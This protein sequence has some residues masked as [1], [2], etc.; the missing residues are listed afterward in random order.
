[1]LITQTL[2][3]YDMAQKKGKDK[4]LKCQHKYYLAQQNVIGTCPENYP[5]QNFMLLAPVPEIILTRICWL[6]ILP[7]VISE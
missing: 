4:F 3:S 5:A 1:M 2:P 7:V 6:N